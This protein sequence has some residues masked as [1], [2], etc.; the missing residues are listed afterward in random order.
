MYVKA[1]YVVYVRTHSYDNP[2]NTCADCRDARSNQL[3]C[4]DRF[5][6]FNCTGDLRCDNQFYYCLRTLGNTGENCLG[7]QRS[8][9]TQYNGAEVDFGRDRVL[10]LANPLP[11]NGISRVWEV[12]EN[13]SY[14][15]IIMTVGVHF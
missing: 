13:S 7:G 11:L 3:G 2:T 5:S 15:C 14:L 4:C 12:S 1:D 9:N 10:G 8:F 6:M